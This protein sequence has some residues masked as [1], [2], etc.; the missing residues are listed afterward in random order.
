M[1]YPLPHRDPLMVTKEMMDEADIVVVMERGHIEMLTARY[2]EVSG[3]LRLLKPTLM[4]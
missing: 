4:S 1:G 2:P 3:K